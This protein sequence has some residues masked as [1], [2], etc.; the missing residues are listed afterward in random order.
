[1]SELNSWSNLQKWVFRFL[2]IYVFIYI[3]P[4]PIEGL[5]NNFGALFVEDPDVIKNVVENNF[6]LIFHTATIIL[7]SLVLS[8]IW[9]AVDRN[10]RNYS[11]LLYW[12]I[13]LLRAFLFITMLVYGFAKI[14][15]IQFSFPPL[16]H[17]L[18]P[19]GEF[20]PM[21]LAWSFFGYSDGYQFFTG[22]LEVIGGFFLLFRRTTTLGALII[23]G[24]MA[25]VA[26][27][28]FAYNIPVKSL[29]AHL[30]LFAFILITFDFKR[31]LNFYFMNRHVPPLHT[32]VPVTNKWYRKITG[33]SS[34]AMA[35]GVILLVI[36][37]PFLRN[38]FTFLELEK[39]KLYGIYQT[40]YM[41]RNG[42]EFIPSDFGEY[43]NYFVVDYK[44]NLSIMYL[45]GRA[46]DYTLSSDSSASALILKSAKSDEELTFN[47]K[48]ENNQLFL[49]N[50]NGGDSLFISLNKVNIK[51]R[52][53]LTP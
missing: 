6:Y 21:R 45:D 23:F 46:E 16:H 29:S 34:K 12:V 51:E 2:T 53:N 10:R 50:S 28:N 43:W 24:V 35:V 27:M 26:F 3:F 49:N 33:F 41:E 5:V 19:L 9:T 38:Q 14:F 39:P 47:Y 17:L 4:I 37:S 31:L 20:T 48:I 18:Q 25:N 15:L 7:L 36:T 1:M 44:N 13:L 11:T 32:D 30:A 40:E 8:L 22:L 42:E 52:F